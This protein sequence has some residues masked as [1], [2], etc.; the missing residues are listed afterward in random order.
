MKKN[1]LNYIDE[2]SHDIIDMS[3]YIYDNPE[4]DDD[5][6]KAM[7]TL[8]TYLSN[9]EFQVSKSI[10]GKNTSFKAVF[11]NKTNGPI[12][13]MLCEYDALSIGHGCGHHIQGPAIVVATKAIKDVLENIPFT[14]VIYGTPAE[15]TTGGKITMLENDCFKELDIALM[16]HSCCGTSV[17][18]RAIAST[19]IDVTFHGKDA[20]AALCPEEGRSALDALLLSFQAIEF[21]REHIKEDSRMHYTVLNAGGESNVVPK[22]A[23]GNFCLRS[24]D[25][26]YLDNNIIKRF[27]DIIKGASLMTGTT[28]EIKEYGHYK[29]HFPIFSLNETMMKNIEFIQAKNISPSREKT[30][31]SDFG[32]VSQ[33][34]PLACLRTACVP[35]SVAAHSK[36]YVDEGKTDFFHLGA[37]NG[38]KILAATA[39]DLITDK[40]LLL[41]IKK[42]FKNRQ[43]K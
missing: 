3:D 21:M 27:Y 22:I 7:E 12:I 17:E 38:S 18:T 5:T 41:K 35:N 13:G 14:L 40:Q 30:G 33:V 28:Y 6:Y 24:Y 19:S 32:N 25:S 2:L 43:Q 10:G 16:L 37:I 42:E 20:H 31:S 34:I 15:E 9:N 26:N 36:E 29:S 4:C 39:Y 23:S 1:L 8:T 11:T